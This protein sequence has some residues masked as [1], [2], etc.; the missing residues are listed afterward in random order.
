MGNYRLKCFVIL[1]LIL[2]ALKLTNK[3]CMCSNTL[4]Q[5]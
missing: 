2:C 5:Q 4:T 3:V 1:F